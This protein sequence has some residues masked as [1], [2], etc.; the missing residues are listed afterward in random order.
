M[1]W[2]CYKRLCAVNT[3]EKRTTSWLTCRCYTRQPTFIL[4]FCYS[5]LD[6]RLA[7]SKNIFTCMTCWRFDDGGYL[8]RNAGAFLSLF[9]VVNLLVNLLSCCASSKT[10]L[11]QQI[12]LRMQQFWEVKPDFFPHT[13]KS[14]KCD[15]KCSNNCNFWS[16]VLSILKITIIIFR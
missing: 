13:R 11:N 7:V 3:L 1:S 15:L 12:T 10:T 14:Q 9:L 2:K 5:L 8:L 6:C 16:S 4:N